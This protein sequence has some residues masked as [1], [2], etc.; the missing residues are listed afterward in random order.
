MITQAKQTLKYAT[1]N[2]HLNTDLYRGLEDRSEV[3]CDSDSNHLDSVI[4]RQY[5]NVTNQ[6]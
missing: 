1:N 2:K 5:T 3:D 4:L 6:C